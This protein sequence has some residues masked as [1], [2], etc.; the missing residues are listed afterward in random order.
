[1]RLGPRVPLY[2]A[3]CGCEEVLE[4]LAVVAGCKNWT[5][6]G[7]DPYSV[8]GCRGYVATLRCLRRLVTHLH[9]DLLAEAEAVC[10]LSVVHLVMGWGGVPGRAKAGRALLRR[11]R[12]GRHRRW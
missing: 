8:A 2:A 5:R 11:G 1:M 9:E 4:W 3:K 12:V 6:A 7:R 10:P